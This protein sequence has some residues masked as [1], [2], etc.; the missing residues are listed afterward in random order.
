VWGKAGRQPRFRNLESRSCAL[1][2]AR[3]TGSGLVGPT[4]SDRESGVPTNQTLEALA[5]SIKPL[6]PRLS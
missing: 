1:A 3:A 4:S 5:P 2:G 6:S